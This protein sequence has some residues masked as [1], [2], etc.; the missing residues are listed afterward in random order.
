VTLEPTDPSPRARTRCPRGDG[1]RIGTPRQSRRPWQ[2]RRLANTPLESLYAQSGIY[3]L[4]AL[5]I[6]LSRTDRA[7]ARY[8]T[9]VLSIAS[10]MLVS[11]VWVPGPS[12]RR[13]TWSGTPTT[14][15]RPR[16]RS[17]RD[18]SSPRASERATRRR[19]GTERRRSRPRPV[20]PVPWRRSN[21]KRGLAGESR[22]QA[23]RRCER[24]SR[25]S[26]LRRR[27]ISY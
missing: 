27:R 12:N 1:A 7:G 23:P 22:G 17:W 25:P 19:S 4:V 3:P 18:S 16:S 21:G 2:A 10:A 15:V 8:W 5:G 20:D 24:R 13:E 11:P 6:A 14:G 9:A 26:K